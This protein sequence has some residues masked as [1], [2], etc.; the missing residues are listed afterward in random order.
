MPT[1]VSFVKMHGLGN[2]FIVVDCL[3]PRDDVEQLVAAA[4]ARLCDRHFGIGGDGLILVLAER[5]GALPHA[6]HQ[7]RRQRAGDVRQ[8]HP[9]SSRSYLST[10]MRTDARN[11]R[12]GHRD[13]GRAD[14]PSGVANSRVATR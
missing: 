8:R 5:D 11:D 4:A 1:P 3:T 7:Q 13:A 14:H 12:V 10:S 2:D 6:H 9:L